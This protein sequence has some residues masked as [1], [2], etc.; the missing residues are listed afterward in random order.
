MWSNFVFSLGA[1][2]PVFAVM[3]LGY[4]L[5][6]AGFLTHGFCHVGN[7]LVFHLA[8][9]ACSFARSRGWGRACWPTGPL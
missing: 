5:R 7:Q 3:V 9:P 2:L 6:R 8:L 4:L 1:T